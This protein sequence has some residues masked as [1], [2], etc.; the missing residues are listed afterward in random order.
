MEMVANL[1]LDHKIKLWEFTVYFFNNKIKNESYLPKFIDRLVEGVKRKVVIDSR[2][3]HEDML[4]K[5]CDDKPT[6][7]EK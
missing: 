6:E 4:N 5:F 2:D 7:N 3:L 1:L